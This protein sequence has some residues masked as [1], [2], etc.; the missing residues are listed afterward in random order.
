VF[1]HTSDEHPWFE[2]S[3]QDRTNPKADW[4]VWADAKPDGSPPSNWQSVFGGPA[5]TWDAR[6]GQYYMHN[7]LASQPQLNVHASGGAG[8]LLATAKFWIDRGVDGFRFDAINFSMHDPALTDNPP[9]R[10]AASAPGRSTSR[11]RST[12]RATPRSR[13]SSAASAP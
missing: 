5:W 12:T 2:A 3:R 4:F 9:C 1:S 7:F 10:R 11:T 8:R 6:R 13:P